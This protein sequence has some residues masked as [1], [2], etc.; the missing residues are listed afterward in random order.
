MLLILGHFY[1]SAVRCSS[2]CSA[3]ISS[4]LVRGIAGIPAQ[5][6][7]WPNH[8]GGKIWDDVSYLQ[9]DLHDCTL[10]DHGKVYEETV[11]EVHLPLCQLCLLFA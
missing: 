4:D 8:A 3:I 9:Y 6:N 5:G 11:C 10:I 1:H 7:V 2:Q